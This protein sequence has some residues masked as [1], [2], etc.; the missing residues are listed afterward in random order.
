MNQWQYKIKEVEMYNS[1]EEKQLVEFLMDSDILE[2]LEE[3]IDEFNA[4]ETLGLTRMEIRHSNALAWLLDSRANHH[5]GDLF[6]RNFIKTLFYSNKSYLEDTIGIFDIALM[7]FHDIKVLREWRNIDIL[8]ICE[9]HKL[10]MCIENKIDSRE[11]KKQLEK[12]YRIVNEEFKE[13]HKIFVYLTPQGEF[14]SDEDN[15]TIFSYLEVANIVK[16]VLALRE[17]KLSNNV[18]FFIE[19]YNTILRRHIVGNSEIEKICQDIYYK[20]QEALDLIFQYKPDIYLEISKYLKELIREKGLILDDSNKTAIRFSTEKLD[21]LFPKIGEGWTSSKRMLLFEFMNKDNKLYLNLII[22]PGSQSLREE[23]YNKAKQDL[24][25]FNKAKK[26]L[27]LKW[28]TIYQTQI[29][30]ESDF[31]DRELEKMQEKIK[32]NIDNFLEN[33]L[34]EI[35]KHLANKN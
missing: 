11:R 22:G 35:E 17:D 8:L 30:K 26:N 23:I 31:D 20:H 34:I 13:Y 10:V 32:V 18:K 12:Y 5:L 3:K 4:F 16:K 2:T 15:W 27:T 14:P 21:L 6:T 33:G 9:E 28:F 7:D 19:Q 24:N 29:L 25:L 1:I